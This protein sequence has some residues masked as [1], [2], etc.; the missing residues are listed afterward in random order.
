M[1]TGKCPAPALGLQPWD[2]SSQ[3]LLVP[4]PHGV[5]WLQRNLLPP[6][7]L[8]KMNGSTFPALPS[9]SLSFLRTKDKTSIRGARRLVVKLSP[10]KKSTCDTR[11]AMP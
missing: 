3:A 9:G 4:T 2:S 6:G 1:L 5:L 11:L 7:N 10:R 8:Q